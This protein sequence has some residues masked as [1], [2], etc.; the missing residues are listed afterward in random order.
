VTSA[1]KQWEWKEEEVLTKEYDQYVNS[2]IGE[3]PQ[4]KTTWERAQESEDQRVLVNR[5]DKNYGWSTWS[6]ER[7]MMVEEQERCLVTSLKPSGSYFI[8]IFIYY[9]F[10]S[11]P[12]SK[13]QFLFFHLEQYWDFSKKCN[14]CNFFCKF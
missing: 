1:I 5:R 2:Q 6:I 10:S 13:F 8:M 3:E 11:I 7:W 12:Y 14:N 4:Q 9:H